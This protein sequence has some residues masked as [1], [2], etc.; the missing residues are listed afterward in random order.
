MPG[1]PSALVL[2]FL[3]RSRLVEFAILQNV[4]DVAR[5]H[6][7]IASGQL[8]Y[9]R[10]R[11][12]QGV[13]L[14]AQFNRYALFTGVDQNEIARRLLFD[15]VDGALNIDR[16]TV[17]HGGTLAEHGADWKR[18]SFLEPAATS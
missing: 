6:R 14:V 5:D 4:R 3:Q 8:R 7:H 13:S 10:L 15:Q 1:R 17:G 11:H 9:L 16:I 2:Q 18:L 12:P